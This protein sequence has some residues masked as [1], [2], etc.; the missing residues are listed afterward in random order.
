MPSSGIASLIRW[1]IEFVGVAFKA[2]VASHLRYINDA[3]SV[4][5]AATA[6]GY[7]TNM[8]LDHIEKKPI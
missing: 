2:F 5:Q 7:S 1:K 4:A 6:I 8:V 3:L